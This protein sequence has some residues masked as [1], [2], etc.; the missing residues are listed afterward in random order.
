MKTFDVIVV[1]SGP[2]GSMAA[3]TLAEKGIKTAILEKEKLPRY[4]TC[5]GGL[6]YRGRQRLP[7]DISNVVE[8]EFYD[9]SIVLSEKLHLKT[10]REF[11]IINMVMRDEF[12]YFLVKKAQI[13]G[14]ELIENCE[15]Q[16]L[17]FSTS[18]RAGRNDKEYIVL[19][20][21]QGEYKA[22]M[23][24]AADGVLSPLSK[25][26]GWTT[27]TRTRIPALEYEVKV[28]DKDFDRL[29][30]DVRF[31][32]DAIPYGYGWCFPK[33]EHLSIGVAT[34][35]P[36]KYNLKTHYKDYLNS[37]KI[38]DIFDSSQHGFQ[39]PVS[40]RTDGFVKNNVFLVGDAAGFP[41]PITAE[42]I[43]NAILSGQLVAESIVKS[44]LDP[45]KAEQLYEQKLA[46][47]LI[48]ELK[49]GELL[50]QFFYGQKRLRNLLLKKYG[51]R[52]AEEMTNIFTG[53]RTYPKNIKQKLK[54]IIF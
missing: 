21:S 9:V 38:I 44:N 18:L 6:V 35:K 8:R 5:G 43:S 14:A 42:G 11:P 16:R 4:K 12:D 49:T 46:E 26:A 30:R 23:V 19:K 25:M 41:D 52:A 34:M 17:D 39:I 20:T 27:D 22:K 37:L 7:F 2:A 51:Q 45:Q 53:H 10:H 33:K 3:Y 13:Q 47:T 54:E 31:D 1:G 48:P 50:S 36:K 15:V 24:I 40:A 28:N 32:I 29:S